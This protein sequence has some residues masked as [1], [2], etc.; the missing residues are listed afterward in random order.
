MKT[1]ENVCYPKEKDFLKMQINS[2][3]GL[4]LG[5]LYKEKTL[6]QKLIRKNSPDEIKT[7]VRCLYPLACLVIAPIG[8]GK[9]ASIALPNLYSLPNSFIVLDIKGELYQKSAGYRQKHFGHKILKFSF[10][11]EE[12]MNFDY[13]QLKEEKITIYLT[14]ES[15][16]INEL[17]AKT[18]LIKTFIENLFKDLMM[19]EENNPDRFVY[20]LFD[21]FTYFGEIPC[22]IKTLTLY[23]KYGFV[24]I[25]LAQS[26]EQIQKCYGKNNFDTLLS[27]MN[28][29]VIFNTDCSDILILVKESNPIKAEINYWFKNPQWEGADKIPIES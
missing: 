5:C 28:Y 23:E 25:Y 27:N 9:T 19:K 17:P 1:C 6:K 22:I 24:P 14:I 20:F 7:F 11:S 8:A 2:E 26:Y 3:K 18:S 4:M 13:K 29:Q 16:M 21:E 12:S 15:E 10:L